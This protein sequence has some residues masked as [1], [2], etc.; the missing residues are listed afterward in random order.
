MASQDV[1]KE[2]Y[3]QWRP[4]EEKRRALAHKVLKES[5]GDLCPPPLPEI[6]S[7]EEWCAAGRKKEESIKNCLRAFF[8]FP[9]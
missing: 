7:Y 3:E 2:Q 9:E 5:L 4:W 1:T 6:P 8:S